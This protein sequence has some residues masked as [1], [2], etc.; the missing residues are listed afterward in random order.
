M[1]RA[2][3]GPARVLAVLAVLATAPAAAQQRMLPRGELRSGVEFVG[4]DVR[5][6]QADDL[7]NPGFLWVESGE[8]LWNATGGARER[9]CA[10]CHGRG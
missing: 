2:L 5:A 8:K 7:A 1:L 3:L 9:S 6:M 10:S 4:P